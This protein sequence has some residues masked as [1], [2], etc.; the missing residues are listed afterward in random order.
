[1]SVGDRPPLGEC[2]YKAP[3]RPAVL[4]P[5]VIQVV[6]GAGAN[7]GADASISG[8]TLVSGTGQIMRS[9]GVAAPTA[10]P[11]L[12]VA[13]GVTEGGRGGG[14]LSRLSRRL[15]LTA[16][17]LAA[18]ASSSMRDLLA[19]MRSAV[20]PP[21]APPEALGP[22]AVG[23][24]V[25]GSFKHEGHLGVDG[26]TGAVQADLGHMTEKL[27]REWRAKLRA[28]GLTKRDLEKHPEL[29]AEVLGVLRS[30]GG[31]AAPKPTTTKGRRTGQVLKSGHAALPPTSSRLRPQLPA[32]AEAEAP[33]V[34]ARKRASVAIT[35][36]G[37][38][39]SGGEGG[40]GGAFGASGQ[41][42]AAAF[43]ATAASTVF[44]PPPIFAQSRSVSPSD[45][46]V[47]VPA[48][49]PAVSGEGWAT[50]AAV[51]PPS[52][53]GRR[54]VAPPPP[55]TAASP[56]PL[57]RGPVLSELLSF[58]KSTM[59]SAD[60]TTRMSGGTTARAA[61]GA[62]PAEEGGIDM[63]SRLRIIVAARRGVM[64]GATSGSESGDE[65]GWSD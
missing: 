48:V 46:P 3:P 7:E 27:P 16:T 14:T 39:G 44:A 35:G 58:D 47:R 24:V 65:S 15:T 6:T 4:P 1:M 55:P 29:R 33:P 42:F 50:A 37:M 12:L 64:K 54:N 62:P 18:A 57:S 28:V 36:T 38:G 31:V 26:T 11:D 10:T 23:D 63:M 52:S 2:G 9:L 13:A 45:S 19:G 56:D 51:M 32:V 40:L 30:S 8:P 20:A 17:A 21:P 41:P 59:R 34:P 25:P 5:G 49:I 60:K 43:A 61:N 53:F 22:I